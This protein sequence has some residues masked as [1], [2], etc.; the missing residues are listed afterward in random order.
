MEAVAQVTVIGKDGAWQ[1]SRYYQTF[2]QLLSS[3]YRSYS[4]RSGMVRAVKLTILTDREA[5]REPYSEEEIDRVFAE[6]LA[7]APSVNVYDDKNKEKI[8]AWKKAYGPK[9]RAVLGELLK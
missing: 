6:V 3:V 2:G 9:L 4:G 8:A 5:S 1:E 7:A